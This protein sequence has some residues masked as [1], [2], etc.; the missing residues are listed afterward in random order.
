M[1]AEMEQKTFMLP[2][3]IDRAEIMQITGASKAKI[4]YITRMQQ[5]GFPVRSRLVNRCAVY[6]RVAVMG[7]LAKNDVS[8]IKIIT[9]KARKER[10]IDMDFN[11]MARAFICRPTIQVTA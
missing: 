7:W 4:N 5:Y 6:D 10:P 9:Y 11:A 2:S 8:K 3:E 1:R